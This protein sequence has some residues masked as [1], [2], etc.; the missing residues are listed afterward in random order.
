MSKLVTIKQA[1]A[2]CE[3][4]YNEPTYR[5]AYDFFFNNNH[6]LQ[7]DVLRLPIKAKECAKRMLPVPTVDDVI[8]WFR[9]KYDIMIYNCIEPFISPADD[10]ILFSYR[11]KKCNTKWG[12][13]HREYIGE[14][15][16][17]KDINAVKRKGIWI[18]I[19]YIKKKQKNAKSRRSCKNRRKGV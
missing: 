16:F 15:I 1:I 17:G 18:A 19:R 9:R 10:K 7:K 2:L 6:K 13:N 8:D 5:Y 14:R 4:G 3:I 11:V 12:W